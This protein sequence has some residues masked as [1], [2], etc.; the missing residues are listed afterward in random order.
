[1]ALQNELQ[2]MMG[3]GVRYGTVQS[4]LLALP[5]WAPGPSAAWLVACQ[6]GLLPAGRLAARCTTTG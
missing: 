2:M 5:A 3:L 1:M 4:A 6:G